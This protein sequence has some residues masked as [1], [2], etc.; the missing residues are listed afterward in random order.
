M[1]HPD[2]HERDPEKRKTYALLTQGSMRAIAGN[3]VTGN[4]VTG[5]GVTGN[6]VRE[7]GSGCKT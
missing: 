7:M 1:F 5:N 2:L 4:G 3:G 6:G